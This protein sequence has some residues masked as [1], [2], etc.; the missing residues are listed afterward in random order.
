MVHLV[1]DDGVDD[2]PVLA[3][4]VVG[5]DATSTLEDFEAHDARRPSIGCSSTCSAT[6]C[7]DPSIIDAAIDAATDR[8]RHDAQPRPIETEIH[9]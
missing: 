5:I 3:T 4:A 2:G 8:A 6:V 7:A 1:P 9:A